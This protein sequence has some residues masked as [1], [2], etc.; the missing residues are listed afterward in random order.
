MGGSGV[1]SEIKRGEA[2][3]DG[4][5]ERDW[6]AEEDSVLVADEH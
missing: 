1:P 6:E 3:E 5:E 2:R 4:A